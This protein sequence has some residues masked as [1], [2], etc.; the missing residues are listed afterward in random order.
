MKKFVLFA[1]ALTMMVSASANQFKAEKVNVAAQMQKMS[2]KMFD[3]ANRPIYKMGEQKI[4]KAVEALQDTAFYGL[5]QNCYYQGYSPTG[6]AY[7]YDFIIAP[8]TDSLVFENMSARHNDYQYGWKIDG[9]QD[10]PVLAEK[11][12]LWTEKNE[13]GLDPDEFYQIMPTLVSEVDSYKFGEDNEYGTLIWTAPTEE[14]APMTQANLHDEKFGFYGWSGNDDYYMG[15]GMDMTEGGLGLIDEFAVL[16]GTQSSTMT[17]DSI[18]LY[19]FSFSANPLPSKGKGLQLMVFGIEDEKVLAEY[20]AL[21]SDI[22]WLEQGQGIYVGQL[23]FPVSFSFTG[24]TE[25]YLYGFNNA[26]VSLGCGVDDNPLRGYDCATYFAYGKSM[27]SFG[28]N[29][30]LF[31][32]A[33]YGEGEPEGISN[34]AAAVKAEKVMKNGQLI[35]RKGDKTFNAVGQIV[36]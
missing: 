9:I 27:Y 17:V 5:P 29:I 18:S 19:F 8:L 20:N 7:P 16:F 21:A 11:F 14:Y 23:T 4:A 6:L 26:G 31:F 35:I 25:V 30:S 33:K 28:S 2:S 13:Q 1:M 36:K 10:Q 34:T 12:I 15:T 32:N 24:M 22:E 3:A